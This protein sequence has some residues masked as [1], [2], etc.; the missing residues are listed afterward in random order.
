MVTSPAP[1]PGTIWYPKTLSYNIMKILKNR[2]STRHSTDGI[3]D[4]VLFN[5]LLSMERKRSE[6]TGAPFLLVLINFERLVRARAKRTIEDVGIALAASIRDTDVTGWHRNRSTL[7]V[8]FTSLKGT[9]RAATRTAVSGKI[10]RLLGENLQPTEIGNVEISFH[11]FPES[12][13]PGGDCIESGKVL[14]AEHEDEDISSKAFSVVKRAIDI[15]G[16]LIALAVLSPVFL[17]I[18]VMIKMTSDGPIFYRQR[19]LGKSGMEFT[20]LKFRS[21][22][23]ANDSKIHKEFTQNLIRGNDGNPTGVYKIQKDPRVTRFGRILRASSLD[24]LP[25][26][27]NV[28]TGT[29]SLVGPRPPIPYEFE[30]YQLWHRRRILEAKPGITGLW[31]VHGRSR[32]TFDDMVRMDLQYIRERSLWIDLKILIKTPF[33]IIGGHGAY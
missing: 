10:Q 17:V 27:I 23:V 1:V 33:A 3:A 28:L 24:E 30:C 13:E 31:Q 6:R 2:Q 26:F 19:R 11:F 8:I 5:R 7:G 18:A 15:V 29:M 20:F 4:E 9:S 14:Y 25:Q 32:T 21:M 16:S 22:Y 12:D